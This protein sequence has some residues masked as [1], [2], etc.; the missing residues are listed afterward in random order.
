MNTRLASGA[1]AFCGIAVTVCSTKLALVDLEPS[2]TIKLPRAD[3]A[4]H[5]RGR[6]ALVDPFDGR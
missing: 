4:H 3:V 5:A 1:A 6:D 2:T